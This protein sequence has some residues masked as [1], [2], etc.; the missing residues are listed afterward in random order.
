MLLIIRQYLEL[1]KESKELDELLPKLLLSM[2]IE[3]IVLPQVGVRQDGVD[4]AAVG[5]FN[6]GPTTLFLFVVKRGHLNRKDWSSDL[7]QAI[8]P[9]LNEVKDVFLKGSL[10][11]KYENLPKKIVLCTGGQLLQ[12]IEKSWHGYIEDNEVKGNIDYEFWGGDQLAPLVRDYLLSEQVLIPEYQSKFR[13]TLA[14][15]GESD[16]NTGHFFEMMDDMLL[17][18][19]FKGRSNTLVL[20]R[21]MKALRTVSVCQKILHVWAREEDNLKAAIICLERSVLVTWELIRKHDL[22]ANKKVNGEFQKIHFSLLEVY[23]EYYKK[24][25]LNYCTQDGLIGYGQHYIQENINLFEHLGFLNNAAIMCLQYPQGDN[26]FSQKFDLMSQCI[27][28]A[29]ANHDAFKTPC[30]D[31]HVIEISTSIYILAL[32]GRVDSIQKWIDEI[33]QKTVFAYNV[34]GLYFPIQSDSFDDLIAVNISGTIN[35]EDMF[36]LSTLYAILAEWCVV[37]GLEDT[38]NNLKQNIEHGNLKCIL[39]IWYP[40]ENT[41]IHL[42]TENAAYKSGASLA[43]YKLESFEEMRENITNAQVNTINYDEISALKYGVFSLP[44][45]ASRHFRMPVLP[46]YW[47]QSILTPQE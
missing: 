4:L 35:K 34:M 17:K 42:Y 18:D 36:E 12:E 38:Y 31:N 23:L 46:W 40:D 2:G 25:E 1:L 10:A 9:T 37:L 14:F 41:D 15:I 6:K 8:R 45:I 21:V 24:M 39:Q 11:K 33:V 32:H 5:S 16:A 30:F 44:L 43:S 28:T 47:Q 19:D 22:F 13:K 27:E 26:I 29:I 3:P 20:S 7:P